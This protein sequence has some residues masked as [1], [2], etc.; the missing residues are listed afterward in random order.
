[1]MAAVPMDYGESLAGYSGFPAHTHSSTPSPYF[2]PLDRRRHWPPAP[3][4]FIG[5]Y[6]AME[7][8]VERLIQ[9]LKVPAIPPGRKRTS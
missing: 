4:N 9:A 3:P 2:P 7:N 1:M 6:E 8:A 5:R